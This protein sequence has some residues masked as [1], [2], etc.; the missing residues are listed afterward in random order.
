MEA[1]KKCE[2]PIDHEQ[3]FHGYLADPQGARFLRSKGGGRINDTMTFTRTS[4]LSVQGPS[5]TLREHPKDG[6]LIVLRNHVKVQN[7]PS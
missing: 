7:V 2:A 3:P 1:P 6:R 4:A 5:R